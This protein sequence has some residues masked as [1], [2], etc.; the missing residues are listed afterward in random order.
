MCYFLEAFWAQH[1][2]NLSVKD[3][4]LSSMLLCLR[5]ANEFLRILYRSGL[6]LSPDRCSSAAR[7]GVTFLKS[8]LEVSHAAYVMDRTR[9]KVTPKYHAMV[10]IVD[11]LVS[12]T[13]AK[14]RWTWSPLAEATQ[15]DEDFIGRVSKITT[16]VDVR[17]VHAQTLERYKTIVWT[18]LKG[19][20]RSRLHGVPRYIN[21]I[22]H[23]VFLNASSK[24]PQKKRHW[25]GNRWLT[26]AFGQWPVILGVQVFQVWVYI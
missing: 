5:S 25:D 9:L 24:S 8:Y 2:A 3:D 12:A 19:V 26:G 7:A 1:I 13:N 4:F 6:W 17:L 18:Q 14:R 23:H 21:S 10:H 16:C 20:K 11:S 15:M 22:I